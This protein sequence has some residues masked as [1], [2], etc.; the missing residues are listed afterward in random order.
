MSYSDDSV[1][2]A[3][4]KRKSEKKKKPE[5]KTVPTTTE[6]IINPVTKRPMKVGG[7]AHK[8]YLKS[9]ST[10]ST[11]EHKEPG[12]FQAEKL[13]E[14]PSTK[15]RK[16]EQVD[17]EIEMTEADLEKLINFA[18]TFLPAKTIDALFNN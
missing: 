4:E 17:E 5:T 14:P 13:T 7:R 15:K 11:S 9:L 3:I 2:R 6:I 8:A 18:Q 16:L 1:L 10:D 12:Q